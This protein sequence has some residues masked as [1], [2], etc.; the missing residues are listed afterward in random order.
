MIL[1]PFLKKCS[2]TEAVFQIFPSEIR[3]GGR[4][5]V[6]KNPRWLSDSESHVCH[7]MTSSICPI[8]REDWEN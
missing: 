4:S 7:R 5:Q 2:N 8:G 3:S 6:R 1:A